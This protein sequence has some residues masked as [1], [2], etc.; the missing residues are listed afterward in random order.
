MRVSATDRMGI[1]GLLNEI[2]ASRQPLSAA[3]DYSIVASETGLR[4]AA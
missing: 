2:D 3:L 1:L 4:A